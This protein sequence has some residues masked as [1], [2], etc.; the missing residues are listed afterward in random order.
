MAF[1][2]ILALI[3]L[4]ELIMNWP[5]ARLSHSDDVQRV[6]VLIVYFSLWALPIYGSFIRWSSSGKIATDDLLKSAGLFMMIWII[7]MY[8]VLGIL[9]CGMLCLYICHSMMPKKNK[10]RER[11]NRPAYD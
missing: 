3:A 5:I 9:T 2:G 7:F 11:R 10:D 4:A 1:Y 6:F 8:T